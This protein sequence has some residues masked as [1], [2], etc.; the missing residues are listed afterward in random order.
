MLPLAL[1]L[2][3]IE[4]Q[5]KTSRPTVCALRRLIHTPALQLIL[6]FLLLAFYWA[7]LLFLF[8]LLLSVRL[9]VCLCKTNQKK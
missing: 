1:A 8:L 5:V 6:S 7:S 3:L 4:G 2:V 9:S